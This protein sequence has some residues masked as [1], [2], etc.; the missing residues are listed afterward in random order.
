[1]AR[2]GENSVNPDLSALNCY[3]AP[4]QAS[5]GKSVVIELPYSSAVDGIA[6]PALPDAQ[7]AGILSI[8]FQ[9]EQTQWWP[10][11]RLRVAQH[12]QCEALLDHAWRT[13]PFL[14]SRLEKA[15]YN[16]GKSFGIDNWT[17]LPP[18]TRADVA[19]AGDDLLSTALPASHGAAGEIFTSGS[20]GRPL[21]AVR[22][23]L[24][25]LFWR[26]FT[27]RD[28]I[29]HRR[30]LTGKLAVI[31]ESGEGKAPW[32]DGSE[33]P[34]WGSS[35][36]ALFDTGPCV[37]LNIRTSTA[38]QMD[39]LVRQDPDYLLTHPTVL[40]GLLAYSLEKGAR[41]PRLKQVETLSELL[42]PETRVLCGEVWGVPV[43]DMYTT[44]EAG[45]LALQCPEHEHYH[46]QGEGLLLE[47]VGPDHKTVKPGETGRVLV[48]P[49]HNFAMPLLRY[50]IGDY[51]ELGA[52]C[53]CG[54][55]LPVLKR[56]L[57]R[58]Q[59]MLVLPGGE[60]RW[61]ML[62]SADIRRMLD[63]APIRQYQFLQKSTETIE[64]R[65]VIARPLTES[66]E[67]ALREFVR[68]RFGHPF[69]VEFRC[70]DDIPRGRTG[71][72]QDFLSEVRTS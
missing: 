68:D 48:T 58:E 9:L 64:L 19:E 37:S 35:S 66:D 39:W 41:L 30:D 50:E 65:L 71:K 43:V 1:M 17:N 69:E 53:P 56:I 57:G 54:R 63:I 12:R 61:P 10:E 13:V 24:W 38:Q 70:L 46:V 62:S 72:Y 23:Q 22:S 14:R 52:P 45:Y 6:W 47:V 16:H 4:S 55:G 8:L 34:R 7:G 67:T 32:P 3:P 44:R 33:T 15:G 42:R 28:H 60:R 49:L 2:R 40:Q 5:R 21:R 20:T 59:N 51:A 27:N 26:A 31:R 18:L 25:E 11:A 29:W 36:G